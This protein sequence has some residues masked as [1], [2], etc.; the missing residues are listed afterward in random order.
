MI[1]N[2]NDIQFA[3]EER[4]IMSEKENLPALLPYLYQYQTIV[5]SVILLL[6]N[7]IGEKISWY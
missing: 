5:A 4:N 6:P 7:K 2:L 3:C 1:D